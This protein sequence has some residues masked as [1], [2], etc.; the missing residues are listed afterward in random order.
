[1]DVDLTLDEARSEDFDALVLRD[2]QISADLLRVEPKAIQFIKDIFEAKKPI[3]AICH[4]PWLLIEAGIIRGRK[5]TS[6]HSIKTGMIN[7][8]TN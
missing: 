4:A 3:A 7:A 6:N 1:M 2:G 5:V 8:D